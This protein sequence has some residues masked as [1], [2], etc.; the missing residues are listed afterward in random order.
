LGQVVTGRDGFQ[1]GSLDESTTRTEFER[2]MADAEPRLRTALVAVYGPDLG[3]EA[4][5]EALAYGWE[6]WARLRSFEN[7]VGYLYRVGQTAAR[8]RR[9][10]DS[11][12]LFSAAERSEPWFE[13]GLAGAL[14]S[15]TDRQRTVVVLVHG[16]DWTLREVA[17]V[18]G[19]RVTSVQNHL[20]RG[21]A[22]LRAALEVT[23]V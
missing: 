2:F 23:N 16:F 20:E 10:S 6:H 7:L 18:S 21:M 22:K 1:V 15:L 4:A 5:A 12:P 17:E 14:A 11:T 8:P 13:P 3:R 9:S 19:L